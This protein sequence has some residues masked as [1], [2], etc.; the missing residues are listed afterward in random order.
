MEEDIYLHKLNLRNVKP[1]A[2]RLLILLKLM[3]MNLALSQQYL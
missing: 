1:T 2:I 3:E